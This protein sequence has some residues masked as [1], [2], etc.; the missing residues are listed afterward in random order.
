[1][2][3][4]SRREVLKLAGAA[5]GAS[6]VVH[7]AWPATPFSMP[8][9]YPG[10]VVGVEHAGSSVRE[11]YQT[12]PIQLMMRRGMM[13]LTG[14]SSFIAAWRK[15]FQPGDV[16][17]IKTSTNGRPQLISSQACIMEVIQGL[18][19]AGIAAK[20]ILVC[21]RY[22]ETLDYI[23]GWL[24]SWVQ[25]AYATQGYLNDQT[26]IAGYDP[27]HYVD[28]P[29]FLLPWQ[30]PAIASHT[31]SYAAQFLTRR[32]TKVIVLSVLKDHQ[33]AGVTMGLKTMSIGGWNN[34]NRAHPDP[35]TN[36]LKDMIPALIAAPVVRN[37]TVL[38]IIDGVHACYAG[39]PT[40]WNGL[41]W[42]HR[43]MYFASDV[44]AADRVGW[45][46]ID[47]QRA[48]MGL[49][50]EQTAPADQYDPAPIRQPQ[51]IEIAGQMG[52]GEWRDEHIDFRKVVLA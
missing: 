37:K 34:A 18:L 36:Y 32:V 12:G 30:N 52:L 3:D 27:D 25:T 38:S 2:S 16:V 48:K 4:I 6:A 45:R 35:S 28:L 22:K 29:Q 24:P 19:L 39:G 7:S 42:E 33:L 9:L 14:A 23:T 15:F 26:G 17:A 8:G 11:A 44:V 31:R 46:A 1:M 21:D 10:R 20:D 40:G 43:T 5:V 49:Q 50:P 47:A 13:E 41:R 51:Y